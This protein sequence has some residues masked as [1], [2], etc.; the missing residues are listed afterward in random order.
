MHR[1]FLILLIG[2][3]IGIIWGL[4]VKSITLLFALITITFILYYL[5]ISY[6]KLKRYKRYIN[7]SIKKELLLVFILGT[8]ISFFVVNLKNQKYEYL[9]KNKEQLEMIATVISQ[10]QEKEYKVIYEIRV[11]QIKGKKDIYKGTHLLLNIK[12][13]IKMQDF[14]YGMQ[15]KIY[16]EYSRPSIARNTNGFSYKNYLK[17]I[18]I[19]GNINSEKIEIIKENNINYINTF[20]NNIKTKIKNNIN[21]LLPEK[22][23]NLLIGILTGDTNKIDENIVEDFRLSSLYHMLAVSGSHVS[24]VILGIG[25]LLN[26]LC[27]NKKIIYIISIFALIFFIGVIGYTPS[28][29]RAVIMAIIL[30]I[31]NLLNRKPDIINSMSISMLIILF[32]NPFTIY[33]VGFWLS[34]GG[35]IGIIFF[36]NILVNNFKNLLNRIKEKYLFK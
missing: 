3:L 8:S 2:Y 10:K 12:N 4:Y 7:L 11:D 19:Y 27:L 25:L 22:E 34:Y 6:T 31:S 29:A 33:N 18:N 15:I 1:I 14:K 9:Y 30:L 28:V 21:N 35:T 26:N 5:I 13:K 17:S 20:L 24:Y 32:I 36:Y 23:G 16:G